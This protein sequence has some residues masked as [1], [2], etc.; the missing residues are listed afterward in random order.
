MSKF[1][2]G[3]WKPEENSRPQLII[4]SDGGNRYDKVA[5]FSNEECVKEFDTWLQALVRETV[6]NM[7]LTA[8]EIE[9]DTENE[10]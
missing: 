2:Y 1:K 10:T 9:E 5:V 3:I 6:T 4:S 7:I 8:H